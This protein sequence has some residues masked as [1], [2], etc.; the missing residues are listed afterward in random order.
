MRKVYLDHSATTPVRPEVL[1]AML[2]YLES[3]FGN[4]SSIHGSGREAKVALEEAREKVAEVI[5]AAPSEVF[6][7]SGGTESDNLAIKGTAFANRKK[8]NHIITSQIEHHAVLESCKFVDNEGFEVTYLPVDSQGLVHGDDLRKAIRD[9]STLVSIMHVNN[10]VGTIQPLEEL[11]KIARD[12][13]VYF[14]SDAVQSVGKI[15]IDVQTSNVDML[16]MSGHKIHGPKGVGALYVRKGVRITPWTHGGHHERSRRAGTENVPGIVGFAR[17]LELMNQELDD[18]CEH[19]KNLTE[20]FYRRL[21]ELIP[22]VVLHGDSSKRVPNI[23]SLSFK[24]VEG[25]SVILSLD[26]RGVAVASGSA[27]TSGTLEPSHVLSAM[28]VP[29]EIA[30]GAV[31]FSFGRDNTM[32][33]VEYVLSLLPEIVQRLRSISPLYAQKQQKQSG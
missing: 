4:A 21:V 20:T 7:T 26:M 33:D 27:C 5:G 23:L 19:M 22:D 17:A 2:P 9:D 24:G 28:R 12:K 15:R 30:Q 32:E 31:R 8:G 14:H 6:F 16:S 29:P 11:G 25:E 10:E 18:Q 3:R 13:G 1:E